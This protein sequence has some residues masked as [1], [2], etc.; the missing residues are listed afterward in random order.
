MFELGPVATSA[1]EKRRR[2]K[3]PTGY[4]N[5]MCR[6]WMKF[7]QNAASLM[8]IACEAHLLIRPHEPRVA[9]HIGGHD[10]GETARCGH[11]RQSSV[12][13]HSHRELR[14]PRD[15]VGANRSV[16]R[17]ERRYLRQRLDRDRHYGSL[18]ARAAD[19]LPATAVESG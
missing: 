15:A 1:L 5:V 2:S 7:G 11:E 16:C 3:F 9:R 8:R 10:R 19:R 14:W 4:S 12:N 18:D 17:H 13:S 6:S